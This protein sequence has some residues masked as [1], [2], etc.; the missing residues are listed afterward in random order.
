MKLGLHY[1]SYREIIKQWLLSREQ[2]TSKTVSVELSDVEILAIGGLKSHF[3][4]A[5]MSSSLMMYLCATDRLQAPNKDP[6]RS[7][8][9]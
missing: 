5:T 8:W 2:K 6:A 3:T 4:F 1:L 7:F 9:A